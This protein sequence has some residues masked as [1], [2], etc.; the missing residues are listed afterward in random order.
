MKD[1]TL[2]GCTAPLS[3][4]L[5]PALESTIGPEAEPN[6]APW[7]GEAM[8]ALGPSWEAAWIDLGGEG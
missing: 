8:E 6:A 5:H 1:R 3:H 2:H 7:C 4:A